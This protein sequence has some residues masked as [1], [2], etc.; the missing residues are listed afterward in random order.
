[1]LNQKGLTSIAMAVVVSVVALLTVGVIYYFVNN[2]SAY[3]DTN[4]DVNAP[5]TNKDLNT[6]VTLRHG[7]VSNACDL[8]SDCTLVRDDEEY[9]DCC[10]ASDCGNWADRQWVAVNK[11][12]LSQYKEEQLGDGCFATECEARPQ[13][14]CPPSRYSF[15]AVCLMGTCAKRNITLDQIEI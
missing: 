8:D 1:M 6:G 3:V 4:N 15:E 14:E 9:A 13:A 5:H 12:A 2:G 11:A 7:V 10:P